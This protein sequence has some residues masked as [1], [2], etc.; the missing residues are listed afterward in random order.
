MD[1]AAAAIK[2]ARERSRLAGKKNKRRYDSHHVD[3]T[4][5]IGDMVW[6]Y[7]PERKKGL[8]EKLVPNWSG[9]YEITG[10]LSPVTYWIQDHKVEVKRRRKKLFYVHVSHLKPYVSEI[11]NGAILMSNDDDDDDF[12]SVSSVIARPPSTRTIHVMITYNSLPSRHSRAVTPQTSQWVKNISSPVQESSDG[13]SE[14]EDEART[15]VSFAN[16]STGS[17]K[18]RTEAERLREAAQNFLNN[19]PPT[20]RTRSHA[21]V[22]KNLNFD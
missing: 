7:S 11:L 10:Q 17:R 18:R 21:R 9:P 4:F 13:T 2:D 6:R 8:N 19:E 12:S 5:K 22:F 14:S 16:V 1:R 15:E 3:V 20:A